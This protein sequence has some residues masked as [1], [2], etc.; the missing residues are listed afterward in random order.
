MKNSH[1]LTYLF[2]DNED[3]NEESGDKNNKNKKEET[4]HDDKILKIE[5]GE[6]TYRYPID[7]TDPNLSKKQRERNLRRLA[8][9]AAEEARARDEYAYDSSDEEEIR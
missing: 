9:R 7:A 5:N 1:M 4:I 2:Q 6:I 8:R 3:E